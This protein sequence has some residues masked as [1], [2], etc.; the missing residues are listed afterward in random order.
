MVA[1]ETAG[2]GLTSFSENSKT[3]PPCSVS[4]HGVAFSWDPPCRSTGAVNELAC[5]KSGVRT[6]IDSCDSMGNVLD[7]TDGAVAGEMLLVLP[8]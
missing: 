5:A 3:Q 8:F 2:G 6:V 7:S 4:D 1:K